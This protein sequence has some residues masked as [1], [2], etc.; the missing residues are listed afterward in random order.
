MHLLVTG[1]GGQRGAGV[2]VEDVGGGGEGGR[3]RG[4]VVRKV[5][6]VGD[7]VVSL[8]VHHGRLVT[9]RVR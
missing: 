8:T 6:G 5:V 9:T 1:G 2:I 7:R 4:A 3:G